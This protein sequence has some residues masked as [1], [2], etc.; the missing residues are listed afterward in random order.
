MWKQDREGREAWAR[1]CMVIIL[2]LPV[3]AC[4]HVLIS[5]G[6]FKYLSCLS[7]LKER[8]RGNNDQTIKYP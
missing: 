1:R 8:Q 6:L 5:N 4:R 7:L 3:T 2:A